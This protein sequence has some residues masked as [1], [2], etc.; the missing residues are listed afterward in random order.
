MKNKRY[1][2]HTLD[3]R[4]AFFCPNQGQ[5]LFATRRGK[6]RLVP[7]LRQIYREQRASRKHR[8]ERGVPEHLEYG[9]VGFYL[10]EEH[11]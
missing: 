9:Y 4:P 10:P 3:G 5:L 1:Y 2:L 7:T 11:I 8:K 6:Q